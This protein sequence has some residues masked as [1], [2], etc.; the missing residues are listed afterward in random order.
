MAGTAT[1]ATDGCSK[2]V[3]CVLYST[4]DANVNVTQPAI[5]YDR[6]DTI[7]QNVR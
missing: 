3:S 2:C 5:R 4:D 1:L 7:M 6:Y